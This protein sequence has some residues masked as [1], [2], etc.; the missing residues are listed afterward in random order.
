MQEECWELEEALDMAKRAL[1]EHY[2][3]VPPVSSGDEASGS[4]VVR[5]HDWAARTSE[6]TKAVDT[7][8][9]ALWDCYKR[10]LRS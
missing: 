9:T 10:R 2:G 1:D 3:P 5:D 8:S 4:A 6:L 7:A